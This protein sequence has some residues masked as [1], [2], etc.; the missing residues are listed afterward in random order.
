MIKEELIN[1]VQTMW[2][3]ADTIEIRPVHG[4][5]EI[6]IHDVDGAPDARCPISTQEVAHLFG[7][8]DIEETLYVGTLGEKNKTVTDLI[9]EWDKKQGHDKC[10]YY[11]EIFRAI[12]TKLGIVLKNDPP[13]MTQ[14]KFDA[15]CKQYQSELFNVQFR[16]TSG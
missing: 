14:E 7:D 2:P 12:A 3:S 9:K 10:H 5:I 13:E 6:V 16:R 11:P 15:G 8:Y 1:F 4:G